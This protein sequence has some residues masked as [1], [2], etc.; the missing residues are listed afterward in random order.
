MEKKPKKKK[1]LIAN[2]AIRLKLLIKL[3]GRIM[4]SSYIMQAD[5][6]SVYCI[7][8]GINA[9]ESEVKILFHEKG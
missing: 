5:K 8:C 4:L 9:I 7:I 2:I 6:F 3:A 1:L